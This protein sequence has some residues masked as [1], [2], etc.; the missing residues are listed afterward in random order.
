VTI[1]SSRTTGLI[2]CHLEAVIHGMATK[3][4]T[5]VDKYITDLMIPQDHVLDVVLADSVAGGLP[6]ISVTPNQGKLLHLLARMLRARRILEIGT[7]GGY[8]TIW[9]ARALPADGWLVTLEA[10]A[11]HAEVARGNIARAKLGD[12]VEVRLGRAKQTLP[13]LLAEGQE[14]FDFIFIDADKSSMPEYFNWALKLAHP[15]SVIVVDNVIRD[16][17]VI[18]ATSRDAAIR[19]VRKFNKLVAA[20]PRVSATEI[21][22]VG[23]KGYDGFALVMVMS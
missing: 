18:D 9:M 15:G 12:R 8:S 2:P 17:R 4:W 21:Q 20:E 14:P 3:L 1:F 23:A 11:T 16:G 13:Q 7:L 5:A 22:T 10:D 19:G 6:D